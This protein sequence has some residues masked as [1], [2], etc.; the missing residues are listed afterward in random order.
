MSHKARGPVITPF[1][2]GTQFQ[3]LMVDARPSPVGYNN[4]K[5]L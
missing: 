3:V 4:I 5:F 2:T 1:I